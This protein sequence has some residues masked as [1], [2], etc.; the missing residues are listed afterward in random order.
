MFSQVDFTVTEKTTL[1]DLLTLQLHMYEEEVQNTVAKAV[2]EMAIEKV[3]V[4]W[5]THVY[6]LTTCLL[7]KN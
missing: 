3:S 6:I 5:F 2:K 7:Q 4:L 1:A